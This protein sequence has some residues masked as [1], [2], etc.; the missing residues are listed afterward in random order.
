MNLTAPTPT[1]ATASTQMPVVKSTATSILITVYS[2]LKGKFGEIPYSTGRPQNKGN[3]SIHNSNPP[4]LE[5]I[6]NAPVRAATPWPSTGSTSQNLFKARKDWPI[7]HTPAPT[8]KT[9]VPPQTAAMSHVMVMPKQVVET[10]SWRPHCPICKNEEEH[11]EE[12]WN[13]NRQV[14][15]P[16]NQCPQNTLQPSHKA[17]S[18]PS[19]LMSLTGTLNNQ[20]EKRVGGKDGMLE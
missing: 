12:D 16:R 7:P 2:L 6:P 17:F 14:E 19:H 10:C 13:S 1:V 15:E 9:E 4:P 18:T 3:P 20:I 8:V 11:G 5:I